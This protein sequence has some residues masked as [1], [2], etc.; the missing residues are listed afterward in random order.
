M[1]D[2]AVVIGNYQ[3]EELLPDL[4][5]SLER[6][7]QPPA[8]VIVADGDSADAS[9]TVAESH[10]ARV[11]R[12]RNGGL[13]FLYNRGAEAAAA[14][15]VLLLN[16]DVELEPSCLQLL[17]R[18]LDED[19]TR[20]AADATQ[21]AWDDGRLVHGRTEIRRGRLLREYIPGLSLEHLLAATAQTAV[22][23]ANGAAMMVRRQKLRELGG[24]DETFFMEWEDLDLCWRAWL[25]DWPS[26]YVPDAVL[27]HRVGAVTTKRVL[28]RRLSSSHHNLVRFALKCLPPAA[29]GRVLA[30]E[31]LRLPR[32]P[33]IVCPALARV[34]R[35]LPEIARLRRE[36]A[37]TRRAFE[38]LIAL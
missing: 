25:R 24:F 14:P 27:R 19:E 36:L 8:E 26:V 29:A 4:L 31:L 6:Q 17:A 1:T 13:G 18:A 33:R 38:E 22:V 30:G 37:P 7:T 5:A 10:G 9:T 28:P 15:Y 3:G 34:V 32:H 23:A 35:E 20:F 21:V 2:V 12:C 16:N 11:L